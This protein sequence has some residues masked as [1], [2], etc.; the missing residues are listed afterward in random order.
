[1]ELRIEKIQF[2]AAYE[3]FRRPRYKSETMKT[4]FIMKR[5]KAFTMMWLGLALISMNLQAVEETRNVK[6]F[7]TVS[8]SIPANMVIS[9]GNMES[10]TLIGSQSDLDK[11]ITKVEN[12]ELIIKK[13]KN[14]GRIDD[15]KILLSVKNLEELNIAGSGDV[16]FKTPLKTSNLELSIAGS[17]DVVCDEIT[18]DEVELS[19][20]GSGDIRLGGTLSK[21]LEISIA[22]SGDVD[23]SNLK[24]PEVEVSIAGSGDA[25]VWAEDKLECSIV[26]S[27]DVRYKGRPLVESDATGS[28]STKPF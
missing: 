17:G 18:A 15:I 27:G 2:D 21:E 6:N 28:G 10:L 16:S 4:I 8:F 24:C 3:N 25:K 5:M 12:G 1:M 23:A 26:G 22:G 11:I 7:S 20:A 19:I 14:S 9:Q 13:K